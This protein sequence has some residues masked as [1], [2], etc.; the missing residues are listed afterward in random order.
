MKRTCICS[1]GRSRAN[2]DVVRTYFLRFGSP[3]ELWSSESFQRHH[4]F[5]TMPILMVPEPG[6]NVFLKSEFFE[7][8]FEQ[9]FHRFFRDILVHKKL[10]FHTNGVRGNFGFGGR[11]RKITPVIYPLIFENFFG[12][13]NSRRGSFWSFSTTD[14]R[15]FSCRCRF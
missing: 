13:E 2:F 7:H 14:R 8:I 12:H 5:E 4:L 3:W 15:Y 10:F 11:A 1:Q 9:I 6:K